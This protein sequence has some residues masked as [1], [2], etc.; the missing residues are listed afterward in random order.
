[1]AVLVPFETMM[2]FISGRPASVR[3]VIL[4]Q[5]RTGL[6][7][8]KTL[9]P[10]ISCSRK[11]SSREKLTG[12]YKASNTRPVCFDGRVPCRY[13]VTYGLSSD[14]KP[15]CGPGAVLIRCGSISKYRSGYG[16]WIGKQTGR[17]PRLFVAAIPFW[18]G[19]ESYGGPPNMKTRTLSLFIAGI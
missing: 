14:G 15:A 8:L 13:G 9:C 18:A 5:F 2:S 17:W 1:M 11:V 3:M 6:F 12:G 19:Y 16:L 7:F 4:L 10:Q